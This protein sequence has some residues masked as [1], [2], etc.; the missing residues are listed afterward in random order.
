M[1]TIYLDFQESL[2]TNLRPREFHT[3]THRSPERKGIRYYLESHQSSRPIHIT[4]TGYTL[5]SSQSLNSCTC[6]IRLGRREVTKDRSKKHSVIIY[7]HMCCLLQNSCLS[8][9]LNRA[10][11][12]EIP[13]A[14]PFSDCDLY[15]TEPVFFGL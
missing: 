11:A 3:H 9:R 12:D 1:Y 15:I 7:N 13:T 4:T 14:P 10:N 8:R 2:G 5:T 6:V